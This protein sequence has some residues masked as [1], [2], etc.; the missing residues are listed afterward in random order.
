MTGTRVSAVTAS[1]ALR[2]CT[3]APARSRGHRVR[4]LVCSYRPVRDHE[5]RV[6]SVPSLAF[7]SPQEAARVIAPL[8][9]D[10]PVEMFAVA[11]LS[12][13]NRLLAWHIVSRGT[14]PFLTCSCRHASH[15][16]R[17]RCWWCTTIPPAIRRRV[18]M[19]WRSR[20]DS[21]R[22]PPFWTSRSPIT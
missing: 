21:N 3:A 20:F 1:T 18:R 11:C 2:D 13:K 16:A 8:M 22:P 4:E 19:M 6:I 7:N 12:A 10:Q 5:G 15:R 9:A 14:R 17:Y